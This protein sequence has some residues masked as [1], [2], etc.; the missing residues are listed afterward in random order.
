MVGVVVLRMGGDEVTVIQ[1]QRKKGDWEAVTVQDFLEE[2]PSLAIRMNRV[3]LVKQISRLAP[4]DVL[5][6]GTARFRRCP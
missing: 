6:T 3:E 5:Y 4:G 2:S 1:R